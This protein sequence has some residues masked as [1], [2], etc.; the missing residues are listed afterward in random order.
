MTLV[1]TGLGELSAAFAKAGR[2]V[3]AG[4]RAGLREVAE[5]V[6][7]DAEVLAGRPMVSG[8]ARSPKW[9][10][11]RIGGSRNMVYVAP[12]QRGYHGRPP[13]GLSE[14]RLRANTKFGTMLLDR[15]MQ[16]ALARHENEIAA[17]FE[18]FLDKVTAD[19][20]E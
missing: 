1:V 19:F 11:M 8:M 20:N 16:P 14:A 6:R 2:E 7:R 18:R 5:P 15:A 9:A 4:F 12:R 10:G 13:G 17:R 3:N